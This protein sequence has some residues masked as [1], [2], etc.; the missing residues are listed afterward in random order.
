MFFCGLGGLWQEENKEFDVPDQNLGTEHIVE[1]A[2]GRKLKGTFYKSAI[3]HVKPHTKGEG[4]G[5]GLKPGRGGV[6]VS[7]THKKKGGEGARKGFS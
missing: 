2:D 6:G 4:G 5:K 3:V 7:R 1:L